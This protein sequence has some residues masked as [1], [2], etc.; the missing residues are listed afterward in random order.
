RGLGA[1]AVGLTGDPAGLQ[2]IR[3]LRNVAPE[4]P[5]VAVGK[6][7]SSGD[8]L[9]AMRAGATDYLWPPFDRQ[10]LANLLSSIPD[11]AGRAKSNRLIC[12][13]PA[14]STD[15]AST[16]ALHVAHAMNQVAGVKP[17]LLDCDIHSSTLA[18]RL[19]TK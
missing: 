8:L 7:E 1:V 12:F 18:F 3:T 5:T 10:R 9:D 19:G 11:R 15:G 16:I 13:A 17:L 2:V 14:Q 4:V 6:T